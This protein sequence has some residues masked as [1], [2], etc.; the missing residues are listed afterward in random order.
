MRTTTMERRGVIPRVPFREFVKGGWKPA[1]RANCPA[2]PAA[3]G[4]PLRHWYLQFLKARL[5]QAR[6]VG[7]S[8]VS[9]GILRLPKRLCGNSAVWEAFCRCLNWGARLETPQI[10]NSVET[11]AP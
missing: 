8:I 10:P 4:S 5:K 11:N 3:R 2:A 7:P 6:V 1:L 9:E